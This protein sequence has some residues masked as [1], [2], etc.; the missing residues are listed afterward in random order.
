[1]SWISLVRTLFR[2]WFPKT[3]GQWYF[4]GKIPD[5]RKIHGEGPFR[6]KSVK[7]GWYSRY[8]SRKT[9]SSWKNRESRQKYF[10]PSENIYFFLFKRPAGP[11]QK[12]KITRWQY[13]I[14]CAIIPTCKGALSK[15]ARCT[16]II[17]IA[18]TKNLSQ[19]CEYICG[20]FFLF[21]R[22]RE[23]MLWKTF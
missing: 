4:R 2:N 15:A 21:A 12:S 9:L 13:Q 14:G 10:S 7:K 22:E 5:S 23:E 11:S 17:L 3:T 16:F 19:R 1:M 20:G 8:P 18:I 6:E